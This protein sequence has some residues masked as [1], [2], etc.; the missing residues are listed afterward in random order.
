MDRDFYGT[1]KYSSSKGEHVRKVYNAFINSAV[2]VYSGRVRHTARSFRTRL[3]EFEDTLS[4]IWTH[5][6]PVKQVSA[7]G[8]GCY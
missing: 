4:V 2:D 8:T 3:P 6:V 1:Y 7:S 5:P